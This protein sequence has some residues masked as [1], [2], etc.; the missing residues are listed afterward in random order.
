MRRTGE[1]YIQNPETRD[2][3]SN[4]EQHCPR[5]LK[6]MRISFFLLNVAGLLPP[7][8]AGPWMRFIYNVFTAG[9]LLMEVLILLGQLTAVVV[10]W[11]D[12]HI[13]SNTMCLMNAFILSFLCCI[14]FL[15]NKRKILKLIDLL[16]D[17]FVVNAKSKNINLIKSADRKIKFYLCHSCPVLLC[18]TFSWVIAPFVNRKTISN[19]QAKNATTK[20]QNIQNMIFV[21]WTPFDIEQSPQFEI[22]T[23]V[24]CFFVN[25]GALIVY[26]VWVTFLS[27]MSHSAAQFKVLVAM[28]ND[29]HENISLNELPTT[30]TASPPCG[31]LDGG[32]VINNVR[33]RHKST[34]DTTDVS[35]W[36]ETGEQSRNSSFRMKFLKHIY[37]H[38]NM[39]E[40][41]FQHYLIYCIKYHKAVTE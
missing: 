12:L 39:E 5:D 32:D 20:E 19:I 18:L 34:N 13:V 35:S 41:K 29:M 25:I 37:E 33:E 22:I 15:Y 38:N 1:Q 2:F 14:Y 30:E 6:I 3:I 27:L 4:E 26:A 40:D 8:R 16:R 17:K 24:Q 21:M 28:L 31:I 23:A 9:A 11:G 7:D 10:Y 36:N